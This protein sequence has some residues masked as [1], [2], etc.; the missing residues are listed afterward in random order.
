MSQEEWVQEVDAAL[1][2]WCQGDFVLGEQWFVY[3]I[4]PQR[5]LTEASLD[6]GAE[7]SDLVEIEIRGFVVVTQTCDIVRSCSSRPFVEVV[8]LV[9]VDPRLAL[10]KRVNFNFSVTRRRW[11]F[12]DTKSPN[13]FS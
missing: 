13:Y 4:D 1:K 7:G 6:P 9:E 8:P 2:K 5:P 11:R 3:R 12:Y 10:C